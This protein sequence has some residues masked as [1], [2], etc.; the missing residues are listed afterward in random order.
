[1][2][3]RRGEYDI[4]RSFATLAVI[5]IHVTANYALITAAGYWGNQITRFAVP[6]FLIISGSLLYRGDISRDS[7]AVG[8]FYARRFNKIL[9][10]YVL[11]T[12]FYVALPSYSA[13]ITVKDGL[14]TIPG[15]LLWGT[16]YYHLYFVA[17]IVQM[18]ILYPLL[19]QWMKRHPR[20]LLWASLLTTLI[21]TVYLNLPQLSQKAVVNFGKLFLIGFPVWIFFFVLGMYFAHH[22]DFRNRAWM[23]KRFSIGLLWLLSLTLVMLDSHYNNNY[24]SSCR[25][26]VVLY[27][28]LSFFFFYALAVSYKKPV[29]RLVNW[30]SQQSFLVYLMHPF[31][32]T[33]LLYIPVQTNNPSLWSGNLGMVS[34]YAA[35][36][37][38]TCLTCY[39]VSLT[40]LAEKIGG[41]RKQQR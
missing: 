10:P 38:L 30:F 36:L 25:P 2:Q 41:V 37:I 32:L 17:I 12:V 33:L 27:A 21:L 4:L 26:S 34:L 3:Q 18:Y 7:V 22:D 5:G 6:M 13:G 15:H 19:H 9:W 39:I 1:M 35:V 14:K 28:T 31:F 8:R 20:L 24:A 40:P 23:Q 29:P 16:G 11:W